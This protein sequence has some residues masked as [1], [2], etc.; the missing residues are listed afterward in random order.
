MQ[1]KNTRACE[2]RLYIGYTARVFFHVWSYRM[3]LLGP[4]CTCQENEQACF[5][6][7]GS[8]NQYAHFLEKHT[9]ELVCMMTCNILCFKHWW[10]LAVHWFMPWAWTHQPQHTPP[11]I[12]GFNKALLRW[13]HVKPMVWLTSHHRVQWNIPILKA[14]V[15][16]NPCRSRRWDAPSVGGFSDN[17]EV[18]ALVNLLSLDEEAF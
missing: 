3:V 9:D 11:Q 12:L 1:V 16:D 4:Q 7:G 10:P 14:I 5:F 2:W 18:S 8:R 13:N 6:R 17:T 15:M